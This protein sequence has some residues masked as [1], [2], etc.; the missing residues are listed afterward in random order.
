MSVYYQ[1]YATLIHS[2]TSVTEYNM[3]DIYRVGQ[4]TGVSF[5]THRVCEL[6]VYLRYPRKG[7][8]ATSQSVCL[9]HFKT[10]GVLVQDA[11][12]KLPLIEVGPTAL[13]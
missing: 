1:H 12:E 7:A 6:S 11:L 4:T 8:N 10:V 5:L 9:L 13:E 3:S 2:A